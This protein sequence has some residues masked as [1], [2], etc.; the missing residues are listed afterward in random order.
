MKELA[1]GNKKVR[2][3]K[4]DGNVIVTE[5]YVGIIQSSK[6]VSKAGAASIEENFKK[7]GYK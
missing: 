2:F 7:R 5:V 1:A 4:F 6:T 3:E